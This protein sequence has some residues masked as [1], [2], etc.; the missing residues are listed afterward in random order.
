MKDEYK[1]KKQIIDELAEMRKWIAELETSEAKSKQAE[2]EILRSYD[3]QR[4]LN[5]LLTL[6]LKDIPSEKLLNNALDLI[7]SIP[8]LSVESKGSIFIVEDNPEVLIMKTQIGLS[9]PIQKA[10]AI[11]PFGRCICGRAALTQEIQFADHIDNRHETLH[12][13]INPHGHYCIPTLFE[14]NTLGVINL[15]LREGHYHNPKE[16]EFLISISHTLAGIL[17]RK[18]AE[19]EMKK[20]SMSVEQSTDWVVITNRH[21]NIEYVNNAVKEITGYKRKELIRKNPKIFQSGKHDNKFYKEMWDTI[22]SGRTFPA[23]FINRKKNGELFYLN[24]TIT[25]LRD[26]KGDIT[27]FI[28]TGKDI[29]QQKFME[30]KINYLAY[31]DALTGLP[32]RN[33]FIDR[34][35][36][37]VARAE[38]RKKLVT[39]IVANIDRFKLINDTYGPSIGDKVLNEVG[40]K[41]SK[42]LREGDTVARLGSDEFGIALI[43]VAHSEDIILLAEKIMKNVA[44]PIKANGEEIVLTLSMGISVYPDAGKDAHELIRNADLALSTAKQQGRKNYQFYTANMNV[45]ASEFVLME[46]HLFNALKNEE[47]ILHYQP[48]WEISTK[49][50]AGMEALIRWKSEELG[51]L[52]PA[53]FIPVLEETGMIIE[54]GE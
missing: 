22:L 54:V 24:Q 23:I 7:L 36:Q 43:D 51:L 1:T 30:E 10:C 37:A 28:A 9:E 12:D 6:S 19:K 47:F 18:K 29:T 40:E 4:A 41:L 48:Y 39:V 38:H 32:N 21:G 25:P 17:V 33:L 44:Q 8:W 49:K 42:S 53:R 16:E 46:R 2:E 27:H 50:T 52:S 13:G 20:L 34:V 5:T 45:I 14:G 31:Y 35:T 26:E 3:T 11:V 15:Y